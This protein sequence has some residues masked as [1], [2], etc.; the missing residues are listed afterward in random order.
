MHTVDL[1]SKTDIRPSKAP[2]VTVIAEVTQSRS[3]RN[4]SCN[5]KDCTSSIVIV[6]RTVA[7]PRVAIS[8][9]AVRVVVVLVVGSNSSSSTGC[10]SGNSLLISSRGAAENVIL[11]KTRAVIKEQRQFEV[12]WDW[13]QQLLQGAARLSHYVHWFLHPLLKIG[14]EKWITTALYHLT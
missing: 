5:S 8:L 7:V 6:V 3:C 13:Q 9:R 1:T 10:S 4:H 12:A 14:L 2:C 11:E